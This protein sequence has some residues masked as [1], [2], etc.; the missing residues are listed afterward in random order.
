MSHPATTWPLIEP[1]AP[2]VPAVGPTSP[3]IPGVSPFSPLDQFG[4]GLIHPFRRNARGDYQNEF[5]PR[6]ITSAVSQILG[7][8]ASTEV[9]QGE[10]PWRPNFGSAL[11]LLR[12]QPNNEVLQS[13]A[14]IHSVEAIQRWEPRVKIT[15]VRVER[16]DTTLTLHVRFNFIDLTTGQAIFEDLEALITI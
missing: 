9:A 1:V 11:Y 15:D 10:V 2:A 14:R 12:H 13:L 6:L 4:R 16:E 3:S 5:G 8:F 7:T